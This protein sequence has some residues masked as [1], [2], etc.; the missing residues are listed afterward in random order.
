MIVNIA[1]TKKTAG[2]FRNVLKVAL[3]VPSLV[4]N[5]VTPDKPKVSPKDV[6]NQQISAQPPAVLAQHIVPELFVKGPDFFVNSINYPMAKKIAESKNQPVDVGSLW[7][8]F[9]FKYDPQNF[10]QNATSYALA[11]DPTTAAQYKANIKTILS[12]YWNQGEILAALSTV[13][14]INLEMFVNTFYPEWSGEWL[15][16]ALILKD[17][18]RFLNNVVSYA[19]TLEDEKAIIDYGKTIKGW[20]KKYNPDKK[21]TEKLDPE[22]IERLNNTLYLEERLKE[23]QAARDAAD[24]EIQIKKANQKKIIMYAVLGLGSIIGLKTLMK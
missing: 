22:M 1:D 9:Y 4:Y 19:E 11:A 24:L 5:A 16:S 2:F 10:T 15:H 20:I 6:I 21:W 23:E 18:P 17:F 13:P 3:P 14:Y 7:H 12:S 8:G